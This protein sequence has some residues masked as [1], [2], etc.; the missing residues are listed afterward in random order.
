MRE[1]GPRR[2]HQSAGGAAALEPSKPI[3]NCGERR[4]VA[5]KLHPAAP[6]GH[7]HQR[8]AGLAAPRIQLDTKSVQQAVATLAKSSAMWT[9]V[10]Y[11]RNAGARETGVIAQSKVCQQVLNGDAPPAAMRWLAANKLVLMEK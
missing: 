10:M 3:T 1:E 2:A 9:P 5:A 8:A 7:G 4:A 11:I 6:A